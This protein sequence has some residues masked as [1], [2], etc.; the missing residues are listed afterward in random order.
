[1]VKVRLTENDLHN[2][3]KESVKRVLKEYDE[4]MDDSYDFFDDAYDEKL[5]KELYARYPEFVKAALENPDNVFYYWTVDGED[6]MIYSPT[7]FKTEDE[8][9]D[10]CDAKMRGRDFSGY[11]E[12]LAAENGKIFS[13][14]MLCN[15]DGFWMD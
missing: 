7:C 12:S 9:A 2:I 15:E 13:D 4:Y 14:T 5:E 11:V 10:D 3:I 8:A 1:M 6:G